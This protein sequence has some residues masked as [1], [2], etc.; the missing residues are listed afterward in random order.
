MICFSDA[1]KNF[2]C[3]R[4]KTLCIELLTFIELFCLPI[5][6]TLRHS[7][8]LNHYKQP[9]LYRYKHKL[10]RFSLHVVLIQFTCHQHVKTLGFTTHQDKG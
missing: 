5:Q 7:L 6:T 8:D 9:S 2:L 4:K 1:K 10:Q 3:M